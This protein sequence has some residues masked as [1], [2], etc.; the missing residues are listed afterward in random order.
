MLALLLAVILDGSC[1]CEKAKKEEVELEVDVVV[2]Q[3]EEEEEE[4]I[5]LRR[6]TGEVR[7]AEYSSLGQN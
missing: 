6:R 2:V 7:P 1:K 5:I 4:T 3:E